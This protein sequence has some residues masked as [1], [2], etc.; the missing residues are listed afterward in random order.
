[1]RI[2]NRILMV[3][4][5]LAGIAL[6]AGCPARESIARINQTPGRFEGREVS[7]AGR[8]VNSFGAMGAGV[9][10]VDDGTGRM[11]V[12]SESYGIP[13][14]DA[15]LAVTGRVEEGFSFGGR[16]FATILRQTRRPSY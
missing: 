1:V 16:H 10:E 11:W 9:Y 14:R 5:L 15:K 2:Q 6:L 12:F 4:M 3:V 13:G 7:I 8:V